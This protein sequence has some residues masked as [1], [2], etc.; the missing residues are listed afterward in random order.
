MPMSMSAADWTTLKRRKAG[1]KYLTDATREVA[2]PMINQRPYGEAL[3]ISADVGG[4]KIRRTAGDFTNYVASQ[5]ADFV[6]ISQGNG[7]AAENTL[8]N[9]YRAQKVTRICSCSNSLNIV[10]PKTGICSKCAVPQ[11]VRIN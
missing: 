7:R 1:T 2:P 3:L 11:H 9:N 10:L 8:N 5:D 6:L 4:S